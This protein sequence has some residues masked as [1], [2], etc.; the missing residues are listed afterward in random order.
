MRGLAQD[1]RYG[2]RALAR[3][4]GFTTVSI[5]VLALGIGANTAMYSA[6]DAL[7]F[8]KIPVRN[9][10]ELAVFGWR[11]GPS[12]DPF[13]PR[14]GG[15]FSRNTSGRGDGAVTTNLAS[16]FSW[17]L[18][19]RFRAQGESLSEIAAFANV[20]VD[21]AID[22]SGEEIT[23]QLI[24]GNFFQMLGVAPVAGRMITPADDASS[25]EAVAVISRGFWQPALKGWN[26]QFVLR[27][28]SQASGCQNT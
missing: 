5:L 4:P 25:S 26:L 16:R 1:I 24:S 28:D 18:V 10:D 6:V 23:T 15:I 20:D 13:S 8:R 12:H 7:F 11:S 17:D 22:G 27:S 14:S 9:P 2:L 19:T 3:S 21:A